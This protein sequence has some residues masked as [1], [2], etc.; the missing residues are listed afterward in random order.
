MYGKG[1][2]GKTQPKTLIERLLGT[3][4][5]AVCDLKQLESRWGASN[6]YCK[7]LVGCGDTSFMT[8]SELKMFKNAT[9]GD[10][11]SLEFK[12][13]DIMK[14]TYTGLFWYCMNELPAFGGDKGQWVYD[15]IVAF[16]C[17][18]VIPQHKRDPKLCDKMYAEREAI[19]NLLIPAINRVIKAGYSFSVPDKC[20]TNTQQYMDDNSP[21][22][23][24]V[25]EC[26]VLT[27]R[28]VHKHRTA[29]LFQ[30]F[31]EWY[32]DNVSSTVNYSNQK[33]KKE[34]A[35]ILNYDINEVKFK[36]NGNEY[37]VISLTE[38]AEKCYFPYGFNGM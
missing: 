35:Q 4:N 15:R 24:F 36:Y 10:S 31:K 8:V 18:N 34:L 16:D 14:Y 6:L 29:E 23:T 20:K 30:A 1:D 33:F 11:I 12:G 21:I 9:G 3:E 17:N 22:R 37:F 27:G 2:T 25:K 28:N 13:D 38:Q 7:R 32:R 19:I 5:F 26:C